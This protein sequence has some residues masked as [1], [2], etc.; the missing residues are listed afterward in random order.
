MIYTKNLILNYLIILWFLY[1][2]QVI[3]SIAKAIAS[4]PG[5][6]LLDV[7]P[8]ASTNRTVYTFVGAP[9]D[10]VKGALSG[11]YAASQLIDMS[12]H[13]GE[14]ILPPCTTCQTH[15]HHLGPCTLQLKLKKYI[16]HTCY[17][18]LH[19]CSVFFR[20]FIFGQRSSSEF[21]KK[22]CCSFS[23]TVTGA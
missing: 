5:C 22:I 1:I 17:K 2:S 7:D 20:R 23:C 21:L 18:V 12:Q 14:S 11:A 3:E 4:V 6:S 15:I 8:G 10:V 9:E 16:F 19:L 13:K